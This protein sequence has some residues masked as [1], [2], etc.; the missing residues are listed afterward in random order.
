MSRIE[1]SKETRA[2]LTR[3]LQRRLKDEFGLEI[4]GL[5]GEELL[6][7][8]SETIGPYFYNQGLQDAQ[9]IFRDKVE[10][11][12]EAIYEIEKPVKS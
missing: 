9:A 11:I 7:F 12:T 4:G 3:K 8:I 10:T 2:N 6:D 5:E 1:L